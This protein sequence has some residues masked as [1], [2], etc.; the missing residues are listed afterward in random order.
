MPLYWAVFSH[1]LK[2]I[3]CTYSVLAKGKYLP[4]NL[5]KKMAFFVDSR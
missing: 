1:N 3:G 2:E 4:A 5:A